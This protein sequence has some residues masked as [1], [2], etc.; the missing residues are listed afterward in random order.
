LSTGNTS[1]NIPNFPDNNKMKPG[2]LG[3]PVEV[4]TAIPEDPEAN[5]AELSHNGDDMAI[6][7]TI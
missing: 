3:F 1:N 5:N 7:T 6:P 4:S 2:S